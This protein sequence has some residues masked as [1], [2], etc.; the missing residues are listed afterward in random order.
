MG[1]TMLAIDTPQTA[2]ITPHAFREAAAMA[3]ISWYHRLVPGLAR[4]RLRR[5]ADMFAA[6]AAGNHDVY[7]KAHAAC[8]AHDLRE[9]MP[10]APSTCAVLFCCCCARRRVAE[11]T[12]LSAQQTSRQ[13]A[14]NEAILALRDSL[15][16]AMSLRETLDVISRPELYAL[17]RFEQ[18]RVA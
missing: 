11:R 16:P 6:V 14:A 4:R 18:Q 13:R 10:E 8:R 9:P 5:A 12:R 17:L 2:R 7:V 1:E 15:N 3:T